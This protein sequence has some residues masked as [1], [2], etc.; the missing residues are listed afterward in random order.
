MSGDLDVDSAGNRARANSFDIAL[1]RGPPSYPAA[2][3]SEG[4][5][6]RPQYK[7]I[8]RGSSRQIEGWDRN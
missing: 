8:L 7:E 1:E 2:K 6:L 4:K 3:K 5:I